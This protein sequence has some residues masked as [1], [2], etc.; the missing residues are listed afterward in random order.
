MTLRLR[1]ALALS[2][3]VALLA[4]VPGVRAQTRWQDEI[5]ALLARRA[6]AVRAG[7]ERA[8]LATM[9][10][11]SEGFRKDGRTWL[12][13]IRSLPLGTYRLDFTEDEFGDLARPADRQRHPGE[14]RIVQ[15]KERIGF[16]SYDAAPSA[17]DLYLTVARGPGGWSVVGDDDLEDLALLSARNV[18]DFGEISHIEAGGIMVVFHPSERTAA[19]RVLSLAGTAASRVK[20]VWPLRWREDGIVIMIPSTVGELE[21]ILQTTFDLSTFVAFAASSL[22]RS[23]GWALTGPRVFLHWPNFRRYGSSFQ[24]AILQH[25]LLH[26]ATRE[27]SGPFVNAILDEGAAQ[28]YGES[29]F[30]PPRPVMRQRVRRGSF[31]RRLV[32]DYVFTAGPPSDIYLAYE[33]SVD[34]IAFLGERFGRG[35]GAR[36]YRALGARDP[37]SPGTW[38]YHLDRACRSVFGT[39]FTTL[40]R[41]WARRAIKELS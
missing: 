37:V 1:S 6:A 15:V 21:R 22:D 11:A 12:R 27:M 10:G 3:A 29:A 18:W 26:L 31:E 30:D 40:E 38:R 14:V 16:R 36:L 20:G 8:F 34:F 33:E 7:D 41:D 24:R 23:A 2:A 5:R 13:R 25:E 19:T 32:E 39:P 17:E 28:Y 35:A 4:P 9:H